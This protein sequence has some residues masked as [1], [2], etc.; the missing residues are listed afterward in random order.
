MP[1]ISE[2]DTA[3]AAYGAGFRSKDLPTAVAVAMAESRLNTDAIG[4]GG[5]SFG[6]WQIHKP[7]HPELF[8]GNANW[9]DP[10]TN[11]RMAKAVHDK[12]GWSAWTMYKNGVYLL[13]ISGAS[14]QNAVR[15]AE[16]EGGTSAAISGVTGTVENVTGSVGDINETLKTV[17]RFFSTGENWARLGMIVL[18]GVLM[19]VAGAIVARP[20]V[21]QAAK[22]IGQVTGR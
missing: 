11:A 18:G 10:A 19:I 2:I 3:R 13:F 9:R 12:Q 6:L 7:S 14:I 16:T 15:V 20:V 5:N 21:D 22:T 4:D 8:A 17:V 1:R